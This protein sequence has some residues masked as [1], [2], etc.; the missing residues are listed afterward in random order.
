MRIAQLVSN[1]HPTAAES[2]KGIYTHVGFLADQFVRLGH[3]THLFGAGNSKT[4]AKLHSITEGALDQMK[5]PED[6]QKHYM[7][8]IASA[9]YEQA[10]QFDIIHNHFALIGA[11]YSKLTTTPTLT[12]MHIPIRD[13][14]KPVLLQYKD[15]PYV[16]FSNSQQ[17]QMPELNWYANIYH[18]VDTELFKYSP[19]PK[20]Y[21]LYL[22][23]VTEDK[24]VHFAIEAAKAA[25]VPLLI[26]GRSAVNED[27]WQNK[28]ESQINGVT[29]R[30]VGEADQ[31]QKIAL[32][33]GARGLLFPTQV[34][35]TFGLV[36]IEA[37]AC[38]TPVIAWRNGA[39]P[40]VVSDGKT[41][42]IVHDTQE[43]VKAIQEID[44]IS[45]EATR[46]RAEIYFSQQKMASGYLRVY[47]RIIEE[48]KR[49]R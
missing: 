22:G 18:G 23:R 20:E 37:M 45:R 24:G 31:T 28:V 1:L 38:G 27:Y 40:E 9:C 44:H 21:F 16:S 15:L 47:E 7:H 33:Q 29:I 48:S 25:N 6:I 13:A 30:Y 19:V 12:S 41:G 14:I 35:E 34:D 43:M 42:F 3:E 17:K 8:G 39:V 11:F 2:T 32:L 26:A 36:M 5:I 46:R 10:G 4:L 49:K